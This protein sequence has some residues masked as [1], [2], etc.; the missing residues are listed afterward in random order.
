MSKIFIPIILGT[1]R[2]G[3]E[4]EKVAK[5][6]LAETQKYGF[7]TELIDIKNYA[8]PATQTLK[9][10]IKN[11][12]S[13]ILKK[14]NGLII[15]SPEYN[16]GYPGELK[17]FL[18]NFYQEYFYKPLA[19]CGVSAGSLGGARMVEQLRLVSIE[20]HMIPIRE[21]VYFSSVKN[22]FDEKENI[23]DNSYKERLQVMFKGLESVISK[24]K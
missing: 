5:F 15:V 17:I 13:S 8:T 11:E 16:H 4:S 1:A 2:E 24:S 22:I 12:L 9:E 18:D 6:V 3:R 23:K 19:I 10:N 20:L 7:E 14:A 21:A